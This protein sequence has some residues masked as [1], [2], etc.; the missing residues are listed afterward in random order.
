VFGR[1]LCLLLLGIPLLVGC[2]SGG[3]PDDLTGLGNSQG[4][5][6]QIA[7]AWAGKL[8]Q[9]G[10]A[11]FKIVVDITASG[12]GR[13]AY[14]DIRCGGDWTLDG[15]QPSTPPRYLFTEVI[16]EG[17][18][19]SCK[20]RGTVT[21]S[22]IQNHAPNRPAYTRMNYSFTGGGVTSRGLLHRIHSDEVV[23]VFKE[24]GVT[25]P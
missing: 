17:A 8:H 16:S 23:P 14:T 12:G 13:V 2:G 7:N 11:P 24:A 25:P 19:G 21:L 6:R 20:G 9:S 22:P 10:M 3:N 1:N 5:T 18:G 15:V 4:I